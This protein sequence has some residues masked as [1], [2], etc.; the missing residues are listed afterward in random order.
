MTYYSLSLQNVLPYLCHMQGM[1][2]HWNFNAIDMELGLYN[3]EKALLIFLPENNALLVL[4]LFIA[5][6]SSSQS[7]DGRS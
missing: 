3:L 5:P 1:R 6:L 7:E 2:S 4:F